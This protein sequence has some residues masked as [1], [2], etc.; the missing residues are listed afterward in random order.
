MKLPHFV[1]GLA[2]MSLA[3]TASAATFVVTDVEFP[4]LVAFHIESIL[5]G[6][7][8]YDYEQVGGPIFLTGKVDG[9]SATETLYIVFKIEPIY[10]K[11]PGDNPAIKPDIMLPGSDPSTLKQKFYT[12]G[13]IPYSIAPVASLRRVIRPEPHMTLFSPPSSRLSPRRSGAARVA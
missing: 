2:F 3:S 5:P 11:N 6:G 1:A 7:P 13:A 4:N 10:Q 9:T 12:A 8:S